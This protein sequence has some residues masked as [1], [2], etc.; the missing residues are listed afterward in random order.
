MLMDKQDQGKVLSDDEKELQ[1]LKD[2]YRR[3]MYE[4][5]SKEAIH[6]NKKHY[7]N[8]DYE[9]YPLIHDDVENR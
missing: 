6:R 5:D 1:N 9:N 7:E 2:K 3:Q 8:K 4:R